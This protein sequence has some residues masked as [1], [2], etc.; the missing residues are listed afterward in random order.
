MTETILAEDKGYEHAE[1]KRLLEEIRAFFQGKLRLVVP[2][3]VSMGMDAA[4]SGERDPARAFLIEKGGD[5]IYLSC[6][7]R[8]DLERVLDAFEQKLN[9]LLDHFDDLFDQNSE[10]DDESKDSL[11][12]YAKVLDKCINVYRIQRKRRMQQFMELSTVDEMR[13]EL[14]L[15]FSEILSNHIIAVLCDALYERVKN[16]SGQIYEIVV[17]EINAFLAGLGV[18][19]KAVVPGE[20][21]DPEFMEAT[22]DSA[23]NFTDDCQKVDTVEKIRRYPYLFSDGSKIIDGQARIWRWK[24]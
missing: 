20:R 14:R 4:R 7:G 18:Y 5:P 1:T 24:N 23:E 2:E 15:L 16:N 19:T 12:C 9:D 3:R 10:L 6:G 22:L 13:D 21:I 8:D 17:R 11:D